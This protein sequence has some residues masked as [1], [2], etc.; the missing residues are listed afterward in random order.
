MRKPNTS[1]KRP[2]AFESFFSREMLATTQES[3]DG[4][5]LP[6]EYSHQM[7]CGG[8]KIEIN[9]GRGSRGGLPVLCRLALG[10][11]LAVECV[12]RDRKKIGL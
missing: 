6:A 5:V 10:F 2:D 9:Y 12:F 1:E 4:G 3:D 11:S 8:V 7:L